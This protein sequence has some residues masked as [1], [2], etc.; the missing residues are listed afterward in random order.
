MSIDSAVAAPSEAA[1][2]PALPQGLIKRHDGVFVDPAIVGAEFKSVVDTVF[3]S[4]LYFSNINYPVFI[5]VLYDCG[6]DLPRAKN[7]EAL[8]RFAS[9]IAPFD[10]QR[11]ALYKAV[12]I[13]DGKAE[14]CFEPVYLEP[15]VQIEGAE[16]TPAQPAALDFDEFVADMWSKGIRFGIDPARVRAVLQASKPERVTVAQRLD[17]VP[18]IDAHIVEVSQDIHRSD[19]PLVM[20]SG[21]LD[22]MSFQ[23]RF[24]QIKQGVKL[25]RKVPRQ[26]GTLG[27]DLSGIVLNPPTPSD[28]QLG[29]IA[30]LGTIIEHTADGEFLLSAQGGFLS[31]DSK[32]GQISINSKIVSRDGVSGRT[33]GN[34]HLNGDYE[35]FGE[36]Q[37]KR[38]IEGDSITIHSD[39]FGEIVSRGGTIVLNGNMVGGTAFNAKGDIRIKGV[40][41]GAVLQTREG[42]VVMGRAESCIVSGTRVVIEY[43]SNCEIM[44]DEVV[45]KQAEGCAIAARNIAIDSAG[46]RKQSEM[47]V[48]ALVPDLGKAD[49]LIVELGNMVEQFTQIELKRRV[50]LDSIMAQP[51]LRKYMMLATKIRKKELTLTP[52]QAPHFQKMAVAVGPA[53]KV[54]STLSL[55]LKELDTHKASVQQ[56][57]AGALRQK[58]EAVV[59][60]SCSVQQFTGDTLIR[61][62]QVDPQEARAYDLPSKEIK[63]RLR[64]PSV[65]GDEIFSGSQGSLDWYFNGAGY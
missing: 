40:A 33:T 59:A 14:Y 51:E 55:T 30:G 58:S 25:L 44:A 52:E 38:R 45:I 24:P 9:G 29:P 46:P 64:G 57:L 23:N 20:A 8:I 16:R 10:A 17:A 56:Q 5:K 53:L 7:G 47:L 31:V 61:T 65:K 6:P 21:M 28:C 3:A 4:N 22:L 54:V 2:T 1:Q 19:A 15:S 11:R 35:E 13:D 41:S 12:K 27:F 49:Q 60:P 43:A 34:L 48:F 63:A 18:G 37:E 39:V 62:L 42:E 36:V 32:S 26:A 50:E